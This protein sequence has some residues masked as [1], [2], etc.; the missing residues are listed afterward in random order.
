MFNT[1]FSAR[2]YVKMNDGTKTYYIYSDNIVVENNIVGGTSSRSCV[3]A[4]KAIYNLYKD[5][6]DFSEIKSIITQEESWTESDYREV[7]KALAA[8]L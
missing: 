8:V 5:E 2:A 3:D 7:V 6:K 1:A 4:A